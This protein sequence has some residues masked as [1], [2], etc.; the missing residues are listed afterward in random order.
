MWNKVQRIYIG[1]TLVRPK[2]K[3]WANTIAYY[4]LETSWASWIWWTALTTTW[5]TYATET[6]WKKYAVFSWTITNNGWKWAT[7][8]VSDY[9]YNLTHSFW[10]KT[11]GNWTA[12]GIGSN[13]W[14]F[15]RL[16]S[17]NKSVYWCS[18][19]FKGDGQVMSYADGTSSETT[20]Y[21]IPLDNTRHHYCMT[22]T[23]SATNL[24]FDGVL[25]KTAGGGSS[26]RYS[27]TMYIWNNSAAYYYWYNW[28][29]SELITENVARTQAEITEYFNLTKWNYWVS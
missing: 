27:W 29:L 26:T 6:T 5:V 15:L 4:P 28:G 10:A 7:V 19:W 3:P 12:S 21:A 18:C 11:T 23:S 25:I 8:A 22:Y 1:S 17:G 16:E 2:W 24:Y 20:W 13:R 9:W 14:D